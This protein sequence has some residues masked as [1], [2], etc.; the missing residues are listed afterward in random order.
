MGPLGEQKRVTS[1]R[2][3]NHSSTVNF[4][5]KVHSTEQ[6]AYAWSGNRLAKLR[7]LSDDEFR[8]ILRQ[9]M[10]EKSRRDL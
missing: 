4:C 3:G 8:G 7:D 5:G 2:V 6:E 9:V 10:I 1:E